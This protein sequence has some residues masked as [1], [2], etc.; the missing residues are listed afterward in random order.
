[1]GWYRLHQRLVGFELLDI[2]SF[3]PWV[4]ALNLAKVDCG[5]H[6]LGQIDRCRLSSHAIMI[7][8]S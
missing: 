4:S 1:M 3:L 7:V 6:R 2:W 5:R 8:L